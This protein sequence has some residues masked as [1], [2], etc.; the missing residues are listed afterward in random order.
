VLDRFRTD[1]NAVVIDV[2]AGTTGRLDSLRSADGEGEGT[3]RA[4]L[5]AEE[6]ID[7]TAPGADDACSRRRFDLPAHPTPDA[8]ERL[9]DGLDPARVV[10]PPESGEWTALSADSEGRATTESRPATPSLS[11]SDPV[12]A[13][14]GIGVAAVERV[15]SDEVIDRRIEH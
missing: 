12:L 9:L 7:G 6:G 3:N 10:E 13:A 8:A 14:E 1:R 15:V 11:R 4:D 5:A 2:C